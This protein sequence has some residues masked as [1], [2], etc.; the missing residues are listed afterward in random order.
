MGWQERAN[1]RRLERIRSGELAS[2]VEDQPMRVQE[3]VDGE[4]VTVAEVYET[5]PDGC[6]DARWFVAVGP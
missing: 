1:R 2:E 4:W 6:L 5:P 3:L